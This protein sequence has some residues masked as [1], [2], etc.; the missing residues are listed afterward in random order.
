M[1]VP[2]SLFDGIWAMYLRSDGRRG[3]WERVLQNLQ[4]SMVFTVL[5]LEE[6]HMRAQCRGAYALYLVRQVYQTLTWR[7]L[8]G[9]VANAEWLAIKG[10]RYQSPDK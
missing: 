6:K 2:R 1:Q 10:A 8:L 3:E 9:N 4:A 7:L 5:W